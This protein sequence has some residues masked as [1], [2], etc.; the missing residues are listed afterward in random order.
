MGHATKADIDATKFCITADLLSR[1]PLYTNRTVQVKQRA[2]FI[3]CSNKELDQLIRDETGGRRFVAIRFRRD[4]DWAFL[5]ALNVEELL[6]RG[7]DERGT[8]PM[9]QQ[10]ATLKAL[11]EEQREKSSVEIWLRQARMTKGW[12]PAAALYAEFHTWED[13]AFPRLG[14]DIRAF[15][16]ELVR[17]AN[18]HADLPLGERR[19][20]NRG[21]DYH[22]GPV[23]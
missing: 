21:T 4:P 19:R 9:Q 10:M 8:D 16:K 1:K 13:S 7:V 3:G 17:L 5:N 2:T 23:A 22:W 18:T 20:T 15:G 6:W 12:Y 11:Q 14:T